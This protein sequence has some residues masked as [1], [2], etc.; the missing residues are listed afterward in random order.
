MIEKLIEYAISEY[1]KSIVGENFKFAVKEDETNYNFLISFDKEKLKTAVLKYAMGRK[2]SL[3]II[4]EYLK[5]FA[6]KVNDERNKR[7]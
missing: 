5:G 1:V 7:E 6:R 2:K 3:K 4:D